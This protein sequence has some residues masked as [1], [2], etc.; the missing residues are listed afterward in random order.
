MSVGRSIGWSVIWMNSIMLLMIQSVI[1]LIVCG[2]GDWAEGPI[3]MQMTEMTEYFSWQNPT[4]YSRQLSHFDLQ[5]IIATTGQS[6]KS[7]LFHANPQD[8]NA[9]RIGSYPFSLC[10]HLARLARLTSNVNTTFGK[11][12]NLIKRSL[13]RCL[14]EERPTRVGALGESNVREYKT[15]VAKPPKSKRTGMHTSKNNQMRSKD[16]QQTHSERTASRTIPEK[17]LLNLDLYL[18]ESIGL[19]LF[20]ESLFYNVNICVF[21]ECWIFGKIFIQSWFEGQGCSVWESQQNAKTVEFRWQMAG[22]APRLIDE[23]RIEAPEA[24]Q[25][26]RVWFNFFAF[27]LFNSFF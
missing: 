19:G 16:V 26:N 5:F 18:H 21:W 2:D 3:Q 13:L 25:W 10:L 14:R 12:G 17:S 20:T 22:E 6:F 23:M 4:W 7:C 15:C 1:R 11:F 8:W 24:F 9:N 27:F